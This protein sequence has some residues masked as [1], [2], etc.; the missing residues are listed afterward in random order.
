MKDLTQLAAVQAVISST[1][2][3][4]K[5]ILK[6]TI[7]GYVDILGLIPAE[8]RKDIV[9][10]VI[11][12]NTADT[13]ASERLLT[14]ALDAA[15]IVIPAVATA[16]VASAERSAAAYAASSTAAREAAEERDLLN[17]IKANRWSD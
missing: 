5:D 12:A 14:K 7:S 4:V 10:A 1:M 11:A 17:Q 16:K 13:A 8:E 3:D 15:V 9:L 6:I 2:S